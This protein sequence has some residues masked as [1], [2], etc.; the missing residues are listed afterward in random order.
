MEF[1]NCYMLCCML[2]YVNSNFAI[3]LKRNLVALPSLSSWCLVIAVWLFLAVSWV[4][5]AVCDC[6]ISLLLL[7]V[8][9]FFTILSFMLCVMGWSACCSVA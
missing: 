2:P 9:V 6:D 8:L 4:L 5:S 7:L 3:I 1:C